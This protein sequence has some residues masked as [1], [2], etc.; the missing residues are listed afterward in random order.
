M[1]RLGE[2]LGGILREGDVVVLTGDAGAGKTQLW[3][4]ARGMSIRDVV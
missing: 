1:Q 3:G 4:V 2:L